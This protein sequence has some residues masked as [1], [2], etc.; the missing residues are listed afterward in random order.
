MD[1]STGGSIDGAKERWEKI[2]GSLGCS[3]N[4]SQCISPSLSSLLYVA[5]LL[6]NTAQSTDPTYAAPPLGMHT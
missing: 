6:S 2:P 4:A 1:D 3:I 5:S